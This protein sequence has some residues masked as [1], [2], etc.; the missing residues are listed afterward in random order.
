MSGRGF[1]LW[2]CLLGKDTVL[3]DPPSVKRWRDGYRMKYQRALVW[4]EDSCGP[5]RAFAPSVINPEYKIEYDNFAEYASPTK[6]EYLL[7]L[8]ICMHDPRLRIQKKYM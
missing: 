5:S 2:D 8:V 4:S 3:S 6:V 1:Q 7:E